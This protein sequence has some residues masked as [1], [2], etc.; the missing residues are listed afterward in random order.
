MKLQMEKTKKL[1]PD[2]NF[3]TED[4]SNLPPSLCWTPAEVWSQWRQ[5][6]RC[7]CRGTEAGA[8]RGR[9]R[10]GAG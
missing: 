2:F 4:N 7:W 1:D 10:T 9:W 8:E 3:E 6:C 5:S